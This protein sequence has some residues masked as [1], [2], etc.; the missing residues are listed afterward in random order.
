MKRL[1][2]HDMTEEELRE[3][4][5]SFKEELFNLRFQLATGQLQNTAKIKQ[6]KKNIA[7]VMTKLRELEIQR[8]SEEKRARGQVWLRP[9]KAR[10]RRKR[11]ELKARLRERLRRV[12][13]DNGS[14]E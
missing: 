8:E 3:K 1:Q 2:I 9:C 4:F 6:V 14:G 12:G 10:S 13:E 11:R 7:R 5:H